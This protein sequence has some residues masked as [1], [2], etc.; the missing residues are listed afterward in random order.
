MPIKKTFNEELTT[1]KKAAGLTGREAASELGVK[2]DRYRKWIGGHNLPRNGIE[3][4]R[5]ASISPKFANSLGL[6]ILP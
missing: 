1:W 2:Y 4:R 6:T 3:R 5:I